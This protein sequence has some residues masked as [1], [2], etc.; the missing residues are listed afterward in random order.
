VTDDPEDPLFYAT[1]FVKRSQWTFDLTLN[2]TGVVT[3]PLPPAWAYADKCVDCMEWKASQENFDIPTW[4]LPENCVNC[5]TEDLPPVPPLPGTLISRGNKCDGAF[6][7]QTIWSYQKPTDACK[8]HRCV[9][10]LSLIGANGDIRAD[11]CIAKAKAD[12]ECSEYVQH[13]GNGLN[14]NGCECYLKDACC[15]TCVP[16]DADF[17]NWEWNVYTTKPQVGDP[18][19]ARGVKSADGAYCCSASC[20]D[21]NGVASCMPVPALQVSFQASAMTAPDGWSVDNGDMAGPRTNLYPAPGTWGTNYGW[22]CALGLAVEDRTSDDGTNYHSTVVKP[23]SK[24]CNLGTVSPEWHVSNV[25]DGFYQVD[26]LYTKPFQQM[27]GCE[28]QGGI[29]FNYKGLGSN[30]MSW[31]SRVVNT[32]NGKISLS[33]G[34]DDNCGAYAAVVIYPK[35][36]VQSDTYCQSLPGMCCPLFV[37]M[38]HRPCATNDPPCKL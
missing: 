26:T 11:E 18:A 10:T 29:N 19:C 3:K 33:G 32:T 17:R 25:P 7:S 37:D 30:D 21:A 38:A 28:I 35:A 8:T 2:S 4:R 36:Q 9:K 6:A 27:G 23:D 15:G 16:V 31:V 20:K 34:T 12:P 1:C 14:Q 13:K 5:E 24:I 22:N